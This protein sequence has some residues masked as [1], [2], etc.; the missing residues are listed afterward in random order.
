MRQRGAQ[1]LVTVTSLLLAA[2][3]S[4][5]SS[6]VDAAMTIGSRA[7]DL[8]KRQAVMLSKQLCGSIP[9]ARVAM[10]LTGFPGG[11]MLSAPLEPAADHI[12]GCEYGVILAT[13]IVDIWLS[14]VMRD[15][16][17]TFAQLQANPA[18]VKLNVNGNRMVW[19]ARGQTLY[20]RFTDKNPKLAGNSQG[21]DSIVTVACKS[22]SGRSICSSDSS[23]DADSPLV[24]L[25]AG[26]IDGIN[27]DK[28]HGAMALP[29]VPS[30]QPYPNLIADN[31]AQISN[32]VRVLLVFQALA[33]GDNFSI[34]EL[35][36]VG[37]G[38]GFDPKLMS[39]D[40]ADVRAKVI[41]SMTT[42]PHCNS[43]GCV[44]PGF[45][46]TGWD[47]DTARADGRRLGI[48]PSK[49]PDP[50]KDRYLAV[51]TSNFPACMCYWSG[52]TAPRTEVLNAR[53]GCVRGV[54][55]I[56]PERSGDIDGDGKP[57]RIKLGVC[58]TAG[59]GGQE[60]IAH[61]QLGAGM[62]FDQVVSTT[63]QASARWE[64]ITDINGDHRND[65]FVVDYTGAHWSHVLVLEYRDGALIALRGDLTVD[66]LV[67][68]NSIASAAG[69]TCSSDNGRA[70]LV[71]WGVGLDS[72]L[73]KYTGDEETYD[74]DSSGA[75]RR[76]SDRKVEYPAVLSNGS[77]DEPKEVQDRAGTHC[78][79]LA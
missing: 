66:Q 67:I 3:V 56:L 46:V 20:V 43:D 65:L 68:D 12:A 71:T 60:L 31:G 26:S 76:V 1:C 29:N 6:G 19:D 69:F 30:T 62:H 28:V 73:G 55:A 38:I 7:V 23:I 33:E 9:E 44:Y 8:A 51:Y 64:G 45:A 39:L 22:G 79:G 74:A 50:R 41:K 59:Y 35:G 10:Y 27:R 58:V 21:V 52:T 36:P 25:A 77:Y 11:F 78:P 48:E 34:G 47:S 24:S 42:H 49:V 40:K 53:R 32:P 5:T 61:V 70:R 75:M 2:C 72:N 14:A 63:A 4:C 18:Y 13:D 57:D 17:D 15:G 16:K 54:E 37:T